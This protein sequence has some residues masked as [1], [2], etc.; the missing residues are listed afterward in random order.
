MS[1]SLLSFARLPCC[2]RVSLLWVA[3]LHHG[4]KSLILL[5]LFT[6]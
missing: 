1:E 5:D 4:T 6:I 3:K 2:R